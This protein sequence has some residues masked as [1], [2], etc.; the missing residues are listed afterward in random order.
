MDLNVGGAVMAG[1]LS[2]FSPCVLPM[3]PF[4]LSYLGGL[5]VRDLALTTGTLR[6]RLVAHAALFACGVTA[7][8]MVLGLG[9]TAMGGLVARWQGALSLVAAAG[10]ALFGLQA[11]G[12]LRLG[13]LSR[14][15]QARFPQRSDSPLAAFAMG[16]AFGFGWTPCVGPTLSVVLMMASTEETLWRGALLLFFYGAAMT[17]PF[18]LTAAF[19]GPVLAWIARHR[20]WTVWAERA[21]GVMLLVFAALIATGTMNRIAAWMLSVTDWSGLLR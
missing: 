11:L 6:R 14:Q 2:F 17:L 3:V 7:T 20:G 18:V 19:S 15:V 16:L 8:F 4:Y 12:L 10:L 13:L 1:F 21:M 9:A 5:P